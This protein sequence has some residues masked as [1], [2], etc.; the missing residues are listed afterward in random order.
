M[1]TQHRREYS[2]VAVSDIPL[3]QPAYDD[4]YDGV[5]YDV[6]DNYYDGDEY[7]GD[8]Y[9]IC[10]LLLFVSFWYSPS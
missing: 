10:R 3:P 2:R 9:L 4:E 6:R 7:V 1:M 5:Y 8:H